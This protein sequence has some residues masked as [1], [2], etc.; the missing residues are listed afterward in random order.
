MRAAREFEQIFLRKMLS[1][2]EKTKRTGKE[3]PMSAGNDIYSSMVVNALS[4][5]IASAGG[6]GLADIIAK[7]MMAPVDRGG[8]PTS[9]ASAGGTPTATAPAP[10][11]PDAA[12]SERPAPP[13]EPLP[14]IESF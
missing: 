12:T 7:S 5:S 6:I 2:L 9:S 1:V 14:P 10:G 4:E 8:A 3:G 11:A 13:G